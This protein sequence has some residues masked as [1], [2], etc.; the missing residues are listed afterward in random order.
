MVSELQFLLRQLSDR[1]LDINV[2]IMSVT[3]Y[4]FVCKGHNHQNDI[5]GILVVD[6]DSP[7]EF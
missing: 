1:G 2:Y 6:D 5:D 4:K 3:Y 7:G